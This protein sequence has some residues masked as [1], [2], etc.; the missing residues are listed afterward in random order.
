MIEKIKTMG[1]SKIQINSVIEK[2]EN[3]DQAEKKLE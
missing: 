1:F 3:L 2:K